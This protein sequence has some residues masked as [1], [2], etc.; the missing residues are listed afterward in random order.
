[1]PGTQNRKSPATSVSVFSGHDWSD[2]RRP[3]EVDELREVSERWEL[4]GS[5]S[6]VTVI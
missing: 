4:L 3:L 1:M 2:E 6:S 5:D